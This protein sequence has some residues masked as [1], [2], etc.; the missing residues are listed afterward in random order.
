MDSRR[1]HIA[2]A[3]H[4]S[5]IHQWPTREIAAISNNIALPISRRHRDGAASKAAAK[6]EQRAYLTGTYVGKAL[7]SPSGRAYMRIYITYI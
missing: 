3:N 2:G 6:S 7:G 1:L 5:C 4:R